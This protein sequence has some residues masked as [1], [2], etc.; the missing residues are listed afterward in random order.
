MCV[1]TLLIPT[2][3]ERKA[4]ASILFTNNPNL[5]E[6]ELGIFSALG[7]PNDPSVHMET[8]MGSVRRKL[9]KVLTR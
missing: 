3:E 1:R 8:C 9:K 5:T 4:Y 6:T 7:F 2:D